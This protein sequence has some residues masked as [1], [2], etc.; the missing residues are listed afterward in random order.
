S[1][2]ASHRPGRTGI[3]EIRATYGGSAL[4]QLMRV[5]LKGTDGVDGVTID[6]FS[7]VDAVFDRDDVDFYVYGGPANDAGN[8]TGSVTAYTL[9]AF[10]RIV[11]LTK[12]KNQP[13]LILLEMRG[14]YRGRTSA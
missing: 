6:G 4:N 3:G 13:L 1:R 9:P 7:G 5:R 11:E 2:I 12:A 10:W 8:G 14:A